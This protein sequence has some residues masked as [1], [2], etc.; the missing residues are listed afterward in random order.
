MYEEIGFFLSVYYTSV[1]GRYRGHHKTVIFD[2][3]Y[4]IRKECDFGY[5]DG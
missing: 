1:M 5:D 4:C 2:V 3:Y